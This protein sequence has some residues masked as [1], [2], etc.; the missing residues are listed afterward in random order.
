[1]KCPHPPRALDEHERA[2]LESG[3][4]GQEAQVRRDSRQPQ[5]VWCARLGSKPPQ[6]VRLVAYV[7]VQSARIRASW[8]GLVYIGQWPLSMSTYSTCFALASSGISP[9]TTHS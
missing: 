7:P 2:G 3:N 9:A 6:D 1:M 5:R 8:T 4:C